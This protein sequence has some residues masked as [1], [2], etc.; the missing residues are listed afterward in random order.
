M[1]S[2]LS[3]ESLFPTCEEDPLRLTPLL[4]TA[5]SS[6]LMSRVGQAQTRTSITLR[7]STSACL[8][9]QMKDYFKFPISG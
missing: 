8:G 4:E 6:V 9:P 7:P 1:K 3:K 5:C 2:K